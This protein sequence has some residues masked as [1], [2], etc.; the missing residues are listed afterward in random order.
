MT[1]FI[2]IFKYLLDNNGKLQL[3]DGLDS[4]LELSLEVQLHQLLTKIS[5]KYGINNMKKYIE[6]AMTDENSLEGIDGDLYIMSRFLDKNGRTVTLL[7]DDNT[8]D[9]ELLK[10]RFTFETIKELKEKGY[11]VIVQGQWI[12]P[13]PGVEYKKITKDNFGTLFDTPIQGTDDKFKIITDGAK[14]IMAPN[15]NF[16][17]INKRT[18][19]LCLLKGFTYIQYSTEN[20]GNLAYSATSLNLAGNKHAFDRVVLS[21]VKQS[22]ISG[23]KTDK[24]LS[25]IVK[26]AS[27]R[28]IYID[29]NGLQNYFDENGLEVEVLSEEIQSSLNRQLEVQKLWFL[30]DLFIK[31]DADP[32]EEATVFTVTPEEFRLVSNNLDIKVVSKNIKSFN[33]YLLSLNDRRNKGLTPTEYLKSLKREDRILHLARGLEIIGLGE[34][35]DFNDEREAR[36]TVSQINNKIGPFLL[37]LIMVKK[38]ALSEDGKW[39]IEAIT[40]GLDDFKSEVVNSKV[41]LSS[42]QYGYDKVVAR[43]FTSKFIYLDNSKIFVPIK[44][45]FSKYLK[46]LEVYLDS[47]RQKKYY[48][49]A[50][51][52]LMNSEHISEF[53]KALGEELVFKKLKDIVMSEPSIPKSDKKNALLAFKL[54]FLEFNVKD[55]GKNNKVKLLEKFREIVF[56][57]QAGTIK[58]D[59]EL[60]IPFVFASESKADNYPRINIKLT[61]TAADLNLFFSKHGLPNL[62]RQENFYYIKDDTSGKIPKSYRALLALDNFGVF[63]DKFYNEM[64]EIEESL[65]IKRIK[66]Q[67][68]EDRPYRHTGQ[69]GEPDKKLFVRFYGKKIDGELTQIRQHDAEA[70]YG[71][72]RN[73]DTRS[74]KPFVLDF[75]QPADSEINEL[76]ILRIYTALLVGYF[77][78]IST[79]ETIFG[80]SGPTKVSASVVAHVTRLG[81]KI[82]NK[83]DDIDNRVLNN[84]EKRINSMIDRFFKDTGTIRTASENDNNLLLPYAHPKAFFDNFFLTRLSEDGDLSQANAEKR[85]RDIRIAIVN[86]YVD[87]EKLGAIM[88]PKEFGSAKDKAQ[89]ERWEA[90]LNTFPPN[91]KLANIKI[92]NVNQLI[93]FLDSVLIFQENILS[94]N[95][96]IDVFQAI[97]EGKGSYI[98]PSRYEVVSGFQ[99][100]LF[101]NG[102]L[103]T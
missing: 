38:L 70:M 21:G 64:K 24:F 12:A 2:T 83:Y 16:F 36:Y 20:V 71:W 40:E 33:D 54:Q 101:L 5:K 9:Y 13:P 48:A 82:V 67:P 17:G 87:F 30:G 11:D 73:D 26:S 6:P 29:K 93:K 66:R 86:K 80:L 53:E 81:C 34:N 96:P 56:E 60:P 41:K 59:I 28:D 63:R 31:E 15:G 99:E 97:T 46:E 58:D 42:V 102:Y 84:I 25:A 10:D 47:Y 7:K 90:F 91:T 22:I 45:D 94:A 19:K 79:S 49:D 8:F 77:F 72:F 43:L 57:I 74:P 51:S 3:R 65:I 27:D 14:L 52:I 92:D 39:R 76:N 68:I 62:H 18:G 75:N 78:R 89:Y 32:P 85:T 100:A 55:S 69:D 4:S 103:L 23:I 95:L 88:K 37:N 35:I 98:D 44:N 1:F 50:Y 61:L